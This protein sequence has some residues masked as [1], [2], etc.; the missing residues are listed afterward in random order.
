MRITTGDSP[1]RKPRVQ[2]SPD[3]PGRPAGART[4]GAG[5]RS[6]AADRIEISGE[7]RGLQATPAERRPVRLEKAGG[8]NEPALDSA[9]LEEIRQKIKD[10]Y[11]ETAEITRAIAD[12][13]L[14]L[15]GLKRPE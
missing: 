1:L 8:A 13:M 11:Y 4:A 7:A 9:Y 14:D 3:E 15:L 5:N 6:P 10:G 12:R 2:Q